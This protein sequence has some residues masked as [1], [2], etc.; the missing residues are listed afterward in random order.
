[1][2]SK[3]FAMGAVVRDSCSWSPCRWPMSDPLWGQIQFQTTGF[4]PTSSAEMAH[5]Q[6]VTKEN[7]QFG[8]SSRSIGVRGHPHWDMNHLRR[9]GGRASFGQYLH[10]ETVRSVGWPEIGGDRC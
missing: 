6:L 3:W 8:C 9:R 4:H 10:V 1:M 7:C 5:S 2:D